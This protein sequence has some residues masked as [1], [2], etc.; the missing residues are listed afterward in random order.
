MQPV[1]DVYGIIA[2]SAESC[3]VRYNIVNG[4][5]LVKEGECLSV[6][7]E[8]CAARLRELAGQLF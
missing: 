2:Y 6:D 7:K 5:I 1:H 8:R 4:R 3:D